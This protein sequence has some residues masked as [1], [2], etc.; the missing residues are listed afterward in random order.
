MR[1]YWITTHW[2]P[3]RGDQAKYGVYLYDGT[4]SVGANMEPGDRV[5][6]YQSKGGRLPLREQPDGSKVKRKLQG[7]KE[8]VIALVEV[9]SKLH[10]IGGVPQEYNNGSVLWWRWKAD[11]KLI[12][13]S[14]FVPRKEL[15]VLLRYMPNYGLRAFGDKHSGVKKIKEDI[16]QKI[17]KAFN[18]NQP[19]ETKSI[20]RDPR[21]YVPRGRGK[22]GEGPVHK[23]L[24]ERVAADPSGVLGEKGLTCLQMEYPFPTSDRA[25]II[26]RDC[27]NRNVAVEIEEIVDIDNIAGVLQAVKYSRMY[28]VERRRMFE[29]VRAFLVA[30]QITD[31]VKDLCK[32][33]G[34]ETFVIN[35]V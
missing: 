31:K 16:H 19:P 1:K 20:K 22:G 33:Y 28:A 29:E 13:Q 6:I 2:P 14:G 18:K 27:E 26:L 11:T 8:G 30:H 25:D 32:Q 34:I 17:L 10:D 3:E 5:W 7:G 4:Q 23:K 21:H 9:V 15:N 35:N 24:K 12:N